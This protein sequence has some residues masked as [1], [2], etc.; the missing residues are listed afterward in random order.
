MILVCGYWIEQHKLIPVHSASPALLEPPLDS[1]C[2]SISFLTLPIHFCVGRSPCWH[3]TLTVHTYVTCAPTPTYM[4]RVHPTF[5]HTYL[6]HVYTHNVTCIHT[7]HTHTY[8]FL[9]HTYTPLTHTSP[10]WP[11]YLVAFCVVLRIELREGCMHAGQR[12]TVESCP[13]RVL[14]RMSLHTS[15]E[16]RLAP[17]RCPLPGGTATLALPGLPQAC[18]L[19][20][21]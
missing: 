3:H 4:L 9:V 18:F 1:H 12:L 5:P 15:T 14:S 13:L 19:T 8:M 17:A 20:H 21:L 7:P 16:A 2:A 10:V 11:L 6:L